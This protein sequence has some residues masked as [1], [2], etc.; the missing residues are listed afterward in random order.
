[1]IKGLFS[2]LNSL[3]AHNDG[4]I[5]PEFMANDLKCS[6]RHVRRR[7]NQFGIKYYKNKKRLFLIISIL[8]ISLMYS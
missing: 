8:S 7:L 6:E 1:M 5:C 4:D 2:R 3:K